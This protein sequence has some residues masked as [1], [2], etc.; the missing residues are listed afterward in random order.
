MLAPKYQQVFSALVLAVVLGASPAD[1]VPPDTDCNETAKA[2]LDES[3][4]LAERLPDKEPGVSSTTSYYETLRT[5]HTWLV[6]DLAVTYGKARCWSGA[7]QAL[8]T[9]GRPSLE[10]GTRVHLL[11]EMANQGHVQSALDFR[12]TL[13]FSEDSHGQNAKAT[14]A[15]ALGRSLVLSG[16]VE[17][18]KQHLLSVRSRW[19]RF[20]SPSYMFVQ[21]LLEAGRFEEADKFVSS[22]NPHDIHYRNANMRLIGHLLQ[23]GDAEAARERIQSI[24]SNDL[25]SIYPPVRFPALLAR[26]NQIELAIR[27]AT[28]IDDQT[29][30]TNALLRIA[31]VADNE[32]HALTA[33]ERAFKFANSCQGQICEIL[34]TKIAKAHAKAGYGP[35]A[36]QLVKTRIQDQHKL[37]YALNKIASELARRGDTR[38]ATQINPDTIQYRDRLGEALAVAYGKSGDF[39]AAFATF[40]SA[41]NNFIK[42]TIASISATQTIPSDAIPRWLQHADGMVESMRA[43]VYQ[44]MMSALSRRG[45]ANFAVSLF[46]ADD[47]T[48]TAARALLGLAQGE[49]GIVTGEDRLKLLKML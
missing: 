19:G 35:R 10:L 30:R 7:L 24:L 16:A 33:L 34:V 28:Q 32:S 31:E 8:E 36:I 29:D 26:A 4:E 23:Q 47:V 27:Y 46:G 25:A 11:Q 17:A 3:V 22:L 5:G 18:G 9:I 20:Q 48:L 41:Q 13:E 37:H 21:A 40:E 15:F 12:D 42:L 43:G 49:L 45:E 14:V 2:F 38:T 44:V 39:Y 6:P 1:A